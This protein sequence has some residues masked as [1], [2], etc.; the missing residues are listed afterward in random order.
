MKMLNDD[1]YNYGGACHFLLGVLFGLI[2][3]DCC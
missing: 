1:V 3:W 2:T